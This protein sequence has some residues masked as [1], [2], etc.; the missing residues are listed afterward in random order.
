MDGSMIN[1]GAGG[2]YYSVAA[3]NAVKS[4]HI[5][6]GSDDI[7]VNENPRTYGFSLRCVAQRKLVTT[8]VS[9]VLFVS[10]PWHSV[11]DGFLYPRL[12]PLIIGLKS[13]TFTRL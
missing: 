10:Y 3:I 7:N 9:I 4:L 11:G 8:T 2:Y 12:A 13:I 6:Y 1:R 5:R